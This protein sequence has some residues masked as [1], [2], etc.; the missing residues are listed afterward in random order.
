M[1]GGGGGGYLGGRCYKSVDNEDVDDLQDDPK[2][3]HF[4]HHATSSAFR[5]GKLHF[6]P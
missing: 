2:F 5:S 6:A 1:R 4:V 3:W